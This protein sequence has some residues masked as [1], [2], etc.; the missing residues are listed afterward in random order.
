MEPPHNGYRNNNSPIYAHIRS[1]SKVIPSCD[2]R[3][4]D[5]SIG[6]HKTN[7]IVVN[8]PRVSSRHCRITLQHGGIL[9]DTFLIEDLSTNG[10][11]L[12]RVKL[13]KGNKVNLADGVVVELLAH[14]LQHDLPPEEKLEFVFQ[15]H[16]NMMIS[17]VS[18]PDNEGDRQYM[19]LY[20]TKQ[21]IGAGNFGAVRLCRRRDTNK[22]YAVKLI[23]KNKVVHS[24]VREREE[25]KNKAMDEFVILREI[26]HPNIVRVYDGFEG[27]KVNYVIMEYVTGGELFDIVK[28]YHLSEDLALLYFRQLLSAVLY[29]HNKGIVHRDIKPENILL[30]RHP[31]PS[32]NPSA[33]RYPSTKE[34]WIERQQK[35][36]EEFNKK[37]EELKKR[38]EAEWELE[39]RILRD[40][41]TKGN[42]QQQ[43]ES[44]LEQRRVF[45]EKLFEELPQDRL[46]A[47]VALNGEAPRLKLTDFG[48][49]RVV[50]DAFFF[51]TLCGTPEYI[52]PEMFGTREQITKSIDM[53]SLGVVLFIMLCGYPPF[54]NEYNEY[55]QAPGRNNEQQLQRAA[56]GGIGTNS[57][58]TQ[59]GP[60]AKDI[61]SKLLRREPTQR[62]SAG[63]CVK[64]PWI[65]RGD[66]KD[67]TTFEEY[68][69]QVDDA[70][71]NCD[72][73]NSLIFF[74]L[75]TSPPI[76]TPSPPISPSYTGLADFIKHG[77]DL[78]S[79]GLKIDGMRKKV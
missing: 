10:T 48:V 14:Q 60:D 11:F 34:E 6:R 61:V 30:E 9:G 40:T 62:I 73:P 46:R 33:Y 43:N 72:N 77:L 55:L 76:H 66:G 32:F 24:P 42:G 58:A 79:S 27:S 71:L 68:N 29:L 1:R 67:D 36:V 22:Q 75:Q 21:E 18:K 47:S 26:T 23:D 37:E 7:A 65:M 52:A 35:R 4:E 57:G 8:D 50:K 41:N 78:G 51:A 56:A 63:E 64:H 28:N 39:K 25:R 20:E 17:N 19:E 16:E 13:G 12:D 54:T 15:Y 45:Y 31:H 38:Q 2:V 49:S 3:L 53:W 5:F 44:E 69:P 74:P 70:D 59:Q